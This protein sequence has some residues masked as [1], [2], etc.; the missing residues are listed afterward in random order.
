MAL[1]FAT[2]LAL[3]GVCRVKSPIARS[4]ASADTD[5]TQLPWQLSDNG[6]FHDGGLV[7]Q[8]NAY[9]SAL[10]RA[11]RWWLRTS[12]L[13]GEGHREHLAYER[14]L[15][16]ITG[17]LA[18]RLPLRAQTQSFMPWAPI[19]HSP[20][21]IC[22]RVCTGISRTTYR[23]IDIVDE[24]LETQ[25]AFVI[26]AVALTFRWDLCSHWTLFPMMANAVPQEALGV[27]C[28]LAA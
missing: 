6:C 9:G 5:T 12:K 15:M 3:V 25:G 24:S 14:G 28:C 18:R 22:W 23:P 1:S 13:C 11:S 16:S 27:L 21:G 2:T 4:T 17:I 10:R 8:Y 26:A 19:R 7:E 20:D